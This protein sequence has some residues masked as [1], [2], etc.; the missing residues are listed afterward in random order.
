MEGVVILRGGRLAHTQWIY[1]EAIDRGEY[2][3]RD[4]TENASAFLSEP[5]RLEEGVT[6]ADILSI[7]RID[8]TLQV[9]FRLHWAQELVEEAFA[10]EPGPASPEYDPEG[11]EYLEIYQIWSFDSVTKT[12]QPHARPDF[13]GVGFELREDHIDRYGN[14]IGEAGT[15]VHWGVAFSKPNELLHLPVRIN[16]EVQI[17][18]DNLDTDHYGHLFDTVRYETLT[19]FQVLHAVIWELT[20]HGVGEERQ[21]K[22]QELEDAAQEAREHPERLVALEAKDL[23]SST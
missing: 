12:Y 22:R 9:V 16:S 8:E 3:S 20:W 1:D 10:G 7:M 21:A 6:L 2:K 14:L 11:L 13:H 15:R 17:V 5:C 4:V 19:L 23:K 18:E